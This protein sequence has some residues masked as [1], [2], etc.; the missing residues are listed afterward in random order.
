VFVRA[1]ADV[2]EFANDQATESPAA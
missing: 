1:F 2:V